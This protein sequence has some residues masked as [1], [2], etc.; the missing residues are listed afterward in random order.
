M[1][2]QLLANLPATIAE[3]AT[4]L[5]VPRRTIEAAIQDARLAGVPIVSDS[6]GVH[7]A[8]DATEAATC[9]D[10]LRRRAISQLLTARALRQTARRMALDEAHVEQPSLWG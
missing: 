8:A 5:H 1:T 2:P 10:A 6:N 9:A 3:L 4:W 7:L